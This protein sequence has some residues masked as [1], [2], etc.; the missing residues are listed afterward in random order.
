[1]NPPPDPSSAADAIRGLSPYAVI[2]HLPDGKVLLLRRPPDCKHFRGRWEFPGGKAESGETFVETLRRE[3]LEET[4]LEFVPGPVVGCAEGTVGAVRVLYIFVEASTDTTKVRLC[5][6]HVAHRWVGLAELARMASLKEP[7]GEDAGEGEDRL[8]PHFREFALDYARRHGFG[9]PPKAADDKAKPEAIGERLPVWVDQFKQERQRFEKLGEVMRKLMEDRVLPL[10]PVASISGRAKTVASFARKILT[11]RKYADPLAEMTDLY[12]IRVIVQIDKEVDAVRRFV[13]DQEKL[14]VID[15]KNS[16]D[17]LSRL[18]SGEFGYRSVHFA[19][20]LAPEAVPEEFRHLNLHKLKAE[21]QIRT[22]LQHAWADIGHDRLYKGAFK[23]PRRFERESA[24]LAALLESADETFSR[25]VAG[26]D[27][28]ECHFGSYLDPAG[29]REQIAMSEAIL[30]HDPGNKG[31]I[32]RLAR[33]HLALDTPG[34]RAAA[35]AAVKRVEENSRTADLW[36]ALG[37][38]LRLGNADVASPQMKEAREAYKKALAAGPDH[39]GSLVGLAEAAATQD[40]KLEAY[41]RAYRANPDDPETVSG[42]IRQKIKVDRDLRFLPPL[43]ATLLAAIER[44]RKQIEVK[45]D[46][47]WAYY[48]MAGFQLLLG[49]DLVWEAYGSFARGIRCDSENLSLMASVLEAL[50]GLL[51]ADKARDGAGEARRMLLAAVRVK[52]PESPVAVSLQALGSVEALLSGPVVIVAGGCD[53]AHE[54]FMESYRSL[55]HEGLKGF[56]GTVVSGG[57][58]QGIAGLVGELSAKAKAREPGY[59]GI[60][61]VGYLPEKLPSGNTATLDE[62]YAAL[63]R[64]R[65]TTGF[66]VMEPIQN[67]IDLLVSGLNPRRVRVVGINGGRIAGFEFQLAWALGAKVALVRDS[68]RIADTF[69]T[70]IRDGEYE[71]IYIVPRDP[72]SVQAFLHSDDDT[73]GML[74]GGARER[75]ARYA[76]ALFLEENRHRHSD[77][78]MQSW[79]SLREDLRGSNLNQVDHMVRHLKAHGYRIV[80]LP[81]GAPPFEFGPDDEDAVEA[82]AMAEHGRWNIER[83]GQ[84][85]RYGPERNPAEKVHSSLVSWEH[86]DEGSRVWD[87]NVVHRYPAMLAQAG[88]GIAR[89]E[90]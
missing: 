50:D 13:R 88:L 12:G 68:G 27:E 59:E 46:L 40:D 17:K 75:L 67:W 72:M 63:R 10:C 37:D 51:V 62:R 78:A 36:C 14:F 60:T 80:P 77:P 45:V 85:W 82:M 48:R 9:P 6:E 56:H 1:M 24:R 52:H 11:K 57:T 4:G 26:L 22:Q 90:E 42:Y 25:L 89:G 8:V 38:A 64:T 28:Y 2:R 49:G 21:L 71:G 20:S 74:P 66:S 43:R 73:A 69:E 53:P 7:D 47:P 70:G 84:G 33:L 55:I 41:D 79:E 86:L 35:E 87:R 3:A 83:I 39:K 31:E 18:R 23:P 65:G 54:E 29:I 34:D 32:L 76:H 5:E 16:E 30:E 44:C 19:V 61:A 81:P 15:E 58:R